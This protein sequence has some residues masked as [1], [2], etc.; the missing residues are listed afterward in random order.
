MTEKLIS[1]VIVTWN[2]QETISNCIHSIILNISNIEIIVIDNNSDDNT[3][4]ILKNFPSVQLY[5]L[6]KNMGFAYA[7]NYGVKHSNGQ[8]LLFLNPDI[9]VKSN[10]TDMGKYIREDIGLVSGKIVNLNGTLQP[11]CYNFETPLNIWTSVFAVGRFMPE[12]IRQKNFFRWANHQQIM[13]PDWVMGSFMIID[14]N[15]FVSIGGFS[16]DYFLYSEDMDLCYKLHLI[17]KKIK[18]VPSFVVMHIGGVS[19]RK[20][21]N[22]QFSKVD[23]AIRSSKIFARK[24]GLSKNV[25][26]FIISFRLRVIIV[27]FL[28]AFMP[29]SKIKLR[30]KQLLI[31]DKFTINS[32]KENE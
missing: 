20:S 13:Y 22:N 2:N 26:S 27:S 6:S 9:V 15:T 1:V 7:N 8:T 3:K 19:E 4:K 14:K 12:K 21:S 10:L 24:Y 31:H 17:Q 25:T 28:Y 18:Y 5:A 30:M 16:E 29:K 23:K 11:S 32:Y